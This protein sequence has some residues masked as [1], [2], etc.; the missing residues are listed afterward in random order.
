MIFTENVLFGAERVSFQVPFR[1]CFV[2]P[3]CTANNGDIA[4][5]YRI[6]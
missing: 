4:A 3:T 2:N 6:V 5:R 1:G